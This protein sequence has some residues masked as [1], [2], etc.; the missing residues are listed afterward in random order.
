MAKGARDG[1]SELHPR[2]HDRHS[3]PSGCGRC[4]A[5]RQIDWVQ[6]F[7]AAAADAAEGDGWRDEDSAH[8]REELAKAEAWNESLDGLHPGHEGQEA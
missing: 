5:A 1:R 7:K 4:D 2:R 3:G 6:I 8:T